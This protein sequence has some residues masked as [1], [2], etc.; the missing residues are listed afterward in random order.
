MKMLVIGQSGQV[1]QSLMERGA[2]AGVDVVARGRPQTDLTDAAIEEVSGN[3]GNFTTKVRSEGRVREIQHGAVVIATGAAEH[4]PD[5]Y[6]ELRWIDEGAAFYRDA[7]LS[8]FS[9]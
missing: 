9:G 2:A 6:L 4:K 3:V 8:Y 5:E 1:A 7:A